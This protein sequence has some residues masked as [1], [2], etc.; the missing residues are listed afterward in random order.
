MN[1][2]FFLFLKFGIEQI[3]PVMKHLHMYLKSTVFE[4]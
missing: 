1:K 2:H 3:F 4:L